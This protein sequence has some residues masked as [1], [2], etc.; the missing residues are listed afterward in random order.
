MICH[1]LHYHVLL[2]R[3]SHFETYIMEQHI[4]LKFSSDIEGTAEKVHKFPSPLSYHWG[5][6]LL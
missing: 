1:I 4:F 2:V 6:Q 5:R 3:A